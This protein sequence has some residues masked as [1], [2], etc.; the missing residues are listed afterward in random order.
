MRKLAVLLCVVATAGL[1]FA[2]GEGLFSIHAYPGY[3]IPLGDSAQTV[4]SGADAL[5][6]ADFRL[7]PV[8]FISIRTDMGY[9]YVPIMSIAGDRIHLISA[10]GGIGLNFPTTHSIKELA[11][12]NKKGL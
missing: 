12:I 7:P 8:P 3:Q 9:G 4:G 5:L 10:G 1:A 2:E 11:S 6:S